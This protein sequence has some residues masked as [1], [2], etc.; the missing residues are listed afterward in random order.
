MHLKVPITGG[1]FLI[2]NIRLWY[3]VPSKPVVIST[4]ITFDFILF[5]PSSEYWNVI[6]HRRMLPIKNIPPVIGNFKCKMNPDY[7]NIKS[8]AQYCVIGGIQKRLY[9]EPLTIYSQAVKWN[10]ARS[11]LILQC[12]LYLQ[13]QSCIYLTNDF[14]HAYNPRRE[15]VCIELT[16]DFNN[17]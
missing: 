1:M 13:T 8:K 10:M 9:H 14:D 2:G 6:I 4:I 12:I 15:Q 17:E 5:V 11:M 16:K 3:L 7:I